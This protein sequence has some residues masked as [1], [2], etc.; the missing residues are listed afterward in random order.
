MEFRYFVL[1]FDISKQIGQLDFEFKAEV[2]APIISVIGRSGAGKTTLVRLLAGL[3]RPDSGFIRFNNEIFYDRSFQIFVHPEKRGIGYIFQSPRLFPHLTVKQNIEL[4]IKLGKR[5]KT[6][7]YGQI[8]EVLEISDLLDRPIDTLSGGQAQRVSIARAICACE[9]LL[10]MDE[11]LS[12]LDPRLTDQLL[13]S[14]KRLPELLNIQILYITHRA[15]E[16]LTL[17]K[18]S[19]L[20]SNGHFVFFGNTKDALEHP[21]YTEKSHEIQ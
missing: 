2:S 20:V 13:S 10:I 19:L 17:S 11:P 12:G 6:T 5:K 18:Q 15:K 8:I 21:S 14:I 4:P 7:N 9:G 3:I 16:A 1:S